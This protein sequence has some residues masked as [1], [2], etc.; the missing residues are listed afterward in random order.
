MDD[1]AFNPP[2][3]LDPNDID[4][5]YDVD[6]KLRF[7]PYNQNDDPYNQNLR[8][9]AVDY[10][11]LGQD[12]TKFDYV[13]FPNFPATW[14][15]AQV[16]G[17]SGGRNC[18]DPLIQQVARQFHPKARVSPAGVKATQAELQGVLSKRRVLSPIGERG[19]RGLWRQLGI[20]GNWV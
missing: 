12:Y 20:G 3:P 4:I 13:S 7:D 10:N 1:D 6:Y 18:H 2:E 17:Q 8:D 16:F 5:A 11:E 19:Y 15:N 9:Q 14:D